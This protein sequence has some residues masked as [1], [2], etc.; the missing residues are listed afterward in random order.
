MQKAILRILKTRFSQIPADLPPR[1]SRVL[2][3]E[4]LS[5]LSVQAAVCPD[6]AAFDAALE[7]VS[8]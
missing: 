3:E 5:E 8:P 6:F 2:D 4:K 7:Q 1:L